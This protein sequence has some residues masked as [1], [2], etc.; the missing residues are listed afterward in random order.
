[1]YAGGGHYGELCAQAIRQGRLLALPDGCAEVGFYDQADGKLHTRRSGI[2]LLERWLGRRVSRN[3]LH[4]RESQSTPGV[5]ARRPPSGTPPQDRPPHG[6]LARSTPMIYVNC[7]ASYRGRW[8]GIAY[9][10]DQLESRS[11]L[12]ECKNNGE[13]ELRALLLAMSAAEQAKLRDIVFR[14]D[15]E[16]AARPDRG[17]SAHLRPLR[18]E[19]CLYLARHQPGWSII[20]ISRTENVLAHALARQARRS[21]DDVSVSVEN[22]V[23]AALIEQAGITETTEGRWRVAPDRHASSMSG[24]LA[25]ALVKLATGGAT[26]IASCGEMQL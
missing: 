22:N 3:D 23:A 21:H 25:A 13:A 1:M 11:R 2:A 4:A 19:V 15:C 20:R 9:Q 7:D 24:A 8:A 6:P 10:S 17:D 26:P 16:S 5:P 18:A 12:V 14:T